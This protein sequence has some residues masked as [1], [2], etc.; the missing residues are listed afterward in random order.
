MFG[1][2]RPALSPPKMPR[3]IF[4]PWQNFVLHQ[5]GS[6]LEPNRVAFRVPVNMTKFDIREYLR[7]LY[8]VKVI[9]VNTYIKLPKTKMSSYR[10][11]F[12]TDAQYKKA[13]VTCEEVIPDEV[14]M[15]HSCRD[16]RLNPA[17][18]K[19]MLDPK[20][21][22]GNPARPG[23]NRSND[24]KPRHRFAWREPIPLLLRGSDPDRPK[25]FNMQD[26]R[27]LDID[28][29]LPYSH[30]T[31]SKEIP[32]GTPKQTFPRVDGD[33]IVN[34]RKGLIGN[35]AVTGKVSYLAKRLSAGN[36]NLVK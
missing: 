7:K 36:I 34:S 22:R 15:I 35:T 32:N 21:T 13:I 23:Q 17:L 33:L 12:K 30:F 25:I 19:G 5:S 31:N 27:E 20:I 16:L 28:K 29:T 1:I 26:E 2:S 3:N 9:K 10:N 6:Y 11:W 4:F 8:G 24:W 18:T 14:K